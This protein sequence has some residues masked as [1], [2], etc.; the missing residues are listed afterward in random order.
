MLAHPQVVVAEPE[1]AARAGQRAA[2]A[3]PLARFEGGGGTGSAATRRK[4]GNALEALVWALDGEG[5]S[6][7]GA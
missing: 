5:P 1:T 4:L 2:D 6:A 7:T 3:M